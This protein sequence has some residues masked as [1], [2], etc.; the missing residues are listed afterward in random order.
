MVRKLSKRKVLF[1]LY[2]ETVDDFL[3]SF[4]HF[5]VNNLGIHLLLICLIKR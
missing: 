5:F 4:V 1:R 3:D 2:L